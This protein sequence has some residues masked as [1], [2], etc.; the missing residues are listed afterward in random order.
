MATEAEIEDLIQRQSA[1]IRRQM[2]RIA[3]LEAENAKLTAVVNG[4][5][6]ALQVLQKVYSD[7]SAPLSAVLKAAG[8]AVNFERARPPLLNIN[9]VDGLAAR[10]AA[11]RKG[12][13]AKVRIVDGRLV[14]PG[15][16]DY[17]DAAEIADGERDP[18]GGISPAA[19]DPDEA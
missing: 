8:I 17:N 19:E 14:D 15:D 16:P 12:E 5:C 9:W 6:D 10:L 13:V 7:T 11:A 3:E 1:C 4:S 18:C 2:D